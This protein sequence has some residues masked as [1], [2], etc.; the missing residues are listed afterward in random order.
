MSRFDLIEMF[1]LN[2]G[3]AVA[4]VVKSSIVSNGKCVIGQENCMFH[5]GVTD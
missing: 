2:V 5:V 4:N 3:G 1:K